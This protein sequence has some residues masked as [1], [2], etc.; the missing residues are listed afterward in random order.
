MAYRED[1]DLEFMGEM[2][3][4][5]LN[6]LVACLTKDKDGGVLLTEELTYSDLYKAHYPNHA[7]YWKEIAAE[8]QCFGANSFATMFRRGKGVLYRE[9]L[10][11]VSDKAK[12]KYNTKDKTSE[13]ENKLLAKFLGDALEKMPEADRIEFTKVVGITNLKTFTPAGLTAALQ[14]AFSA[15]GFQSYQ[16]ALMVANAVSSAILGRGLALAANATFMRT[17]SLLT[18]PIGWTL[19]GAWTVVDIAGPAFRITMPSVIQV[20]LL[21]KKH[22]AELE[23]LKKQIAEELG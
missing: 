3:S 1:I 16:L 15:G 22:S 8:V 5:D 6:D 17:A 19:T 23:G 14:L 10:T 4:R 20:A 13:I 12:V 11:D 2:S 18:G 9:V 21:R 7:K